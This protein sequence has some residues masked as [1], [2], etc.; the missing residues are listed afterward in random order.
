MSTVVDV[1][2]PRDLVPTL[3][4]SL[5][6]AGISRPPRVSAYK[7]NPGHPGNLYGAWKVSDPEGRQVQCLPRRH[8]IVLLEIINW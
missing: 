7:D 3:S 5:V 6:I 8:E 4:R 2:A 1:S